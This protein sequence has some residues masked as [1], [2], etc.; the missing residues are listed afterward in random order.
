MKVA[1]RIDILA[2]AHITIDQA[3]SL[4][5]VTVLTLEVPIDG[6]NLFSRLTVSRRLGVEQVKYGVHTSRT[7]AELSPVTKS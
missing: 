1:K 7:R 5:H 4:S 3:R 2:I 6:H